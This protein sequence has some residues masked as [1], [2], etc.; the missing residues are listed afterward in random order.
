MAREGIARLTATKIHRIKEPG[1][2]ADGGNLYLSVSRG[3][4][5]NI[6]RSWIFRYKLPFGRQRDLGLGSLVTVGLRSGA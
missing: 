6:R 5:G 3:K 2:H 4:T 1:L